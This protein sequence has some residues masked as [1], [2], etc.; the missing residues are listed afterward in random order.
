M[1]TELQSTKPTIPVKNKASNLASQKKLRA[2]EVNAIVAAF[3]KADL[4]FTALLEAIATISLTPGDD[5]QSALLRT[6]GNT[7]QWKLSGADTWIDLFNLLLLAGT[8]G[9][10]V[11]LQKTATHVQWRLGTGSW[12]NLVPLDD[13]KGGPGATGPYYAF[14]VFEGVFQIRLISAAPE[15]PWINLFYATDEIETVL[16]AKVPDAE[17]NQFKTNPTTNV[18]RFVSKWVKKSSSVPGSEI[19]SFDENYKIGAYND[20]K[21]FFL[22]QD[23][24]DKQPEELN[25]V[26]MFHSSHVIPS[27]ISQNPYGWTISGSYLPGTE[28][29]NLLLFTYNVDGSIRLEIFQKPNANTQTPVPDLATAV[30]LLLNETDALTLADFPL[31]DSGY[32]DVEAFIRNG[33][34]ALRFALGGINFYRIGNGST[35][36]LRS[37]LEIQNLPGTVQTNQ[38]TFIIRMKTNSALGGDTGMDLL[39]NQNYSL[40]PGNGNL[41]IFTNGAGS[42]IWV[43]IDVNNTNGGAISDNQVRGAGAFGGVT[44]DNWVDIAV[45]FNSDEVTIYKMISG[46]LTD[47]I[48]QGAV[49]S[50]YRK[51]FSGKKFNNGLPF[52]IGRRQDNTT[53]RRLIDIQNVVASNIALTPVQITSIITSFPS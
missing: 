34:N 37:Y 2:T 19:V 28:N 40:L 17:N 3:E 12:A 46:T 18:T 35:N 21:Y 48:T 29:I 24:E 11:S 16:N 49:G 31:V 14:R 42:E 7:L 27:V 20:P 50:P 6:V 43:M 4:N 30:R 26:L 8:N 25:Q 22:D 32:F 33:T 52:L 41:H 23:I 1:P 10:E 5:G 36:S 13:I 39:S 45:T 38:F 44:G 9:Q 53:V 15:D 47:I 51:K